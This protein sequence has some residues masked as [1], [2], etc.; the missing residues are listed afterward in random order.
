MVRT[1]TFDESAS[2]CCEIFNQ[3]RAARICSTEIISQD[4]INLDLSN[5]L[6]SETSH[7]KDIPTTSKSSLSFFQ[8]LPPDIRVSSEERTVFGICLSR[9][10]NVLIQQARVAG[11][12]AYLPP[13]LATASP[14][15][16]FLLLPLAAPSRMQGVIFVGWR[17]SGQAQLDSGHVR[18]L[19]QLL[20]LSAEAYD[21]LP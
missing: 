15:E 10:E 14:F 7:G 2:S 17:H 5:H 4:P 9:A 19:R 21:R 11:I 20:V 18:L 6:T 12:Q 8:A 16:A 3:A 13:W 1:S